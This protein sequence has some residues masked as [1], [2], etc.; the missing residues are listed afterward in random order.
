MLPWGEVTI[1][2]FMVP[3][4]LAVTNPALTAGTVVSTSS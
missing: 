4:V 3:H 1:Q 2:E